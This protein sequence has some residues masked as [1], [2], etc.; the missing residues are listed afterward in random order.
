MRTVIYLC[1]D[2]Y[3]AQYILQYDS[4]G[5]LKNYFGGRGD[6][7]IHFDNAHG[8]CLTEGLLKQ[9]CLSRIEHATVLNVSLRK[10]H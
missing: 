3:G 9:P 6:G 8:I 2:G 4:N 7:D 5:K 10:E 1:A